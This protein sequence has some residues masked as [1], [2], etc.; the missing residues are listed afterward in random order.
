MKVFVSGCFDMLHSGHLAFLEE[1]ASHGDL[2]VGIGSDRTIRELKGHSPVCPQEER[3]Y[4]LKGLRCVKDAWINGG[5][6]LLDFQQ[7]V[8]AL[9]PD[10]FFVNG[11]GYTPEKEAFCRELG[12]RLLVSRRIPREGLPARSTTALR[13]QR[14]IP[15]RI[16]LG[17][18]WLDQPEV[19]RLATGPVIT[20][21]IE[22]AID[23]QDRSGLATS[24]RKKAMEF[25]GET[26]PAGNRVELA[27]TLFAL[28]NPPGTPHLSGSQ[29]QL[30]LLLPG[31]NRLHYGQNTVWPDAIDSL[32]DEE[33]LRFV[34]EHLWLLTLSPRRDGFSPRQGARL[35]AGAAQA[36]SR[37]A[38]GVWEGIRTRDASLWG[39]STT[40]AFQAACSLFPAMMTPEAR[41]AIRLCEKNALGWKLT[42]A[43]GGGYLVVVSGQEIPQAQR[44]TLCRS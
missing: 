12:I 31:V 38:E 32:T 13:R 33:T 16:E 7:E 15:F 43:G 40:A 35:D 25:W 29:D 4:M 44:I 22:P 17:G 2:Y 21:S 6:G 41:E 30:G 1:A 3:L 36:L 8:R 23:F 20:A 9:K 28:E 37:A 14:A 10:I 39:K 42:G 11:D 34:E 19:N 26:L 18:G 5:S 24:S 27:K